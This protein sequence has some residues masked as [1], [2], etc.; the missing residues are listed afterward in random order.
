MNNQLKHI[1]GESDYISID[2]SMI[3][4]SGLN[5]SKL[6]LSP[7]G[8]APLAT[9]FIKFI[10]PDKQPNNQSQGPIYAVAK[11]AQQ[12]GHAMQI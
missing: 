12:F 2:N 9:H 5:N 11:P 10:N 4:E 1:C 7:K 3:D 8:S 6:H